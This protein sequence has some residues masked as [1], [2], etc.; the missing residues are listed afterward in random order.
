MRVLLFPTCLVDHIK[1]KI[2]FDTVKLLKFYGVDVEVPEEPSCCGQIAFNVGYWEQ[3]RE[4]AL[5]WL[6]VYDKEGIDYIV[7]PS[8]SCVHMIRENY[9]I[10]FENEPEVLEKV[11]RVRKKLYE[12]IEFM[13]KVLKVKDI[14]SK[15]KGKVTYHASCHYLRGLGVKEP[16]RD[17]LIKISGVKFIPMDLEE[18]CCGFGGL[19]SVKFPY[20][21]YRMAERKVKSIEETGAE[22]LTSS[23]LSCLMNLGGV[24]SRL[25]IDIKPVHIVEILAEGLGNGKD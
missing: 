14:P 19:F 10:L 13:I 22:Y 18:T 9:P 12:I 25:G 1:P 11:N 2:G 24:L 6:R 4:M 15:F 5:S 8:G 3:A 21:S 16:P 20:V 23:D 17:F 7:A